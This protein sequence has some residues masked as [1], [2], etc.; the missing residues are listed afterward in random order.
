MTKIIAYIRTSTDKQE[1]NNQKLVI[2][3]YAQKNNLAFIN[4]GVN[5]AV[6]LL[7]AIEHFGFDDNDMIIKLTGRHRIK[8]D[9]FFRL[10][11]ENP[12]FDAYFKFRKPD[13]TGQEW[14]CT[15][16]FAMRYKYLK[17]MYNSI[18]LEDTSAIKDNNELYLVEI[19]K[20]KDDKK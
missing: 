16:V 17:H 9:N 19:D 1:L 6:T 10:V 14:A 11:K 12:N 15:V 8:S 3:E 20:L 5:E 18:N 7:E 4:N 13:V 2:L